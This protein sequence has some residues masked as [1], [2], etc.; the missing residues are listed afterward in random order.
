M[1][2]TGTG[3]ELE[4]SMFKFQDKSGRLL[5]L[6][7]EMTA[8]IARAVGTKLLSSP[9]PIRLYYIA[10]MFRYDEPQAGRQREFWQAG[11]ELVGSNSPAAD[12][13]VIALMIQ[14]LK[15]L[16]LEGVKVDIGH[17]GL[18]KAV[19]KQANLDY[20]LANQ[21]RVCIDKRDRVTLDKLLR[22]S[23]IDDRTKEFITLLPDLRGGAEVFDKLPRS[24][25]DPK[26]RECTENL[27]GVLKKLEFYDVYGNVSVD[28][29]IIR[30]IDY[31]TG[32]VFEAYVPELGVAIGGGGRYDELIS[33]FSSVQIPATG[34][35][36][37]IDRCLL[38]LESQRYQ[39]PRTPLSQAIVLST[40]RELQ[41]KAIKIAS[42]LRQKG[43]PTETNVSD[44]SIS[45]GLSYANRLGIPYA[46]IVG[47]EELR[48]ASVIVRNMKSGEQREIK[49]D[50]VAYIVKRD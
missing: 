7:A 30:G 28:L 45:R 18:F 6:R 23:N 29:S 50:E 47:E 5:A 24:A 22:E 42:L 26:I 39:F 16:G 1:L 40:T 49:I 48:R 37:G 10:N 21:I 15:D 46:V 43:I 20:D 31:Y 34:F 19:V 36:I 11:I 3:A 35:A 8:P 25:Y 33:E 13:E 27:R 12:A 9:K 41:G 14:A 44:W 32:V 4:D 17:V 38:S 2:A